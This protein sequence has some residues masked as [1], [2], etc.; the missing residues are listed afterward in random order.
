M[1][2]H[3]QAAP[4]PSLIPRALSLPLTHHCQAWS[5]SMGSG[6][7][8]SMQYPPVPTPADVALCICPSFETHLKSISLKLTAHNTPHWM[9][10]TAFSI[11]FR[12][13]WLPAM[14]CMSVAQEHSAHL[15]ATERVWSNHS[16]QDQHILEK[17]VSCAATYSNPA[18]KPP[19]CTAQS[20]CH[21]HVH[22]TNCF[23]RCYSVY[24]QNHRIVWVG[25]HP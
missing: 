14:P 12:C 4:Q 5:A 18:W 1:F 25:G 6:R 22:S 16:P 24:T 15:R 2:T 3:Q 17:Q 13:E 7:S 23:W 21:W 9:Q 10:H 11:P 8:F 19:V 20:S